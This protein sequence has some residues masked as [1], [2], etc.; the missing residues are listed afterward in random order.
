MSTLYSKRPILC[1]PFVVTAYVRGQSG[2][3][4]ADIPACCPAGAGEEDPRC[5]IGIHHRRERK[6]GP[7][8][9]FVATCH[10]HG[11][12]FSL[13]PPAYAPYRGSQSHEWLRTVRQLLRRPSA[14]RGLSLWRRS[15]EQPFQNRDICA[16]EHLEPRD[17]TAK[18]KGLVRIPRSR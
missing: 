12:S 14:L 18:S 17:S 4:V 16:R 8:M 9:V 6:T 5:R 7:R 15:T 11:L 1:R 3:L 2:E 13:Y 10:R